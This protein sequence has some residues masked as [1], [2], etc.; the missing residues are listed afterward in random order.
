MWFMDRDSS[1]LCRA[2]LQG[3]GTETG[4]EPG[5]LRHGEQEGESQAPDESKVPASSSA[6][7]RHHSGRLSLSSSKLPLPD[8]GL[9]YP[10][11]S[12]LASNGKRR[13]WC[14][15]PLIILIILIILTSLRRTPVLALRSREILLPRKG[16]CNILIV[17]PDNW[18]GKMP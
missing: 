4:Q 1:M 13:R 6:S 12:S 11:S 2:A 10:R 9:R 17:A 5:A 3:S 18:N 15:S 8:R 16:R 14:Q 7:S